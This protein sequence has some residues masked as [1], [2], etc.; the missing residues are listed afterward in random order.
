M[1]KYLLDTNVLLDL[2]LNRLP[3]AA[4]M[5]VIWDAH[6]QGQIKAFA[7]AF[8]V[9]TI[10]YI[11]RKQAGLAKAR[12]AT[13]ACLTTLDIAATNPATLLAA[14]AFSGLDFEDD[15]QIASAVE[16]GVDGIVTRDP[17]G[18]AAS[19]IPIFTPADLVVTLSSP[20]T[21]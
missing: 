18:F 15:L 5:A 3:W 7:A 6:R 17:R 1:K 14:Q 19:P 8:A 20:P 4:D 11:V 16:A 9:P 21:P 13:N 2:F 12:T 10:F